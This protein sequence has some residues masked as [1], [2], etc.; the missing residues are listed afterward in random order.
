[1][2]A[3]LAIAK[4]SSRPS[5]RKRERIGML[6]RRPSE[7]WFVTKR[8]ARGRAKWF[9]RFSITG[10][11]PRLFGPFPS[12]RKTL[13]FLDA[14]ICQIGDYWNQLDEARDK[15]AIEGEFEMVNWG[16]I[17]EHPLATKDGGR[18]PRK[19]QVV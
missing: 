17:I 10:L 9:C 2:A 15:Y 14:A 4:D 7:E 8:T 16:P 18:Q 3:Q 1:M 13:L 5:P 6:E 19:P 11:Y 12:K